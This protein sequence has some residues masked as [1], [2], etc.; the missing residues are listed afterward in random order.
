MIACKAAS[1]MAYSGSWF[2]E[3]QIIFISLNSMVLFLLC[4]VL[5]MCFD[6]IDSHADVALGDA[7]RF[8]HFAIAVSVE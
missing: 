4:Q 2:C 6:A 1:F 7:D 8:R 5:E 3:S